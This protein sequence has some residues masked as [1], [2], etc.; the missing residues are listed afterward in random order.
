MKRYLTLALVILVVLVSACANFGASG[1][2]G[3]RS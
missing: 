3:K 1:E 2:A